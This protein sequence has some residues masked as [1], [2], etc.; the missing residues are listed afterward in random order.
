MT[1]TATTLRVPAQKLEEFIARA[2]Q[3]VGCISAQEAKSIPSSWA[4]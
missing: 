3:V 1:D 4:R 2:F